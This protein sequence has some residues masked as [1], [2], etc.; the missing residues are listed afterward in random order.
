MKKFLL[1]AIAVSLI[2]MN[3]LSIA[4]PALT[5]L[6]PG[7]H[8]NGI[9][10]ESKE[11]NYVS[12]G[13]S[14][15]NGFVLPGYE[16][17]GYLEVAQDAYPA[18]FSAWLAGYEGKIA[19]GQTKYEGPKGT[20]NLTQLATSGTRAEDL[21]YVLEIVK[22]DGQKPDDY[23]YETLINSGRWHG[24]YPE[25]HKKA[26]TEADIISMAVGNANLGVQMYSML[27]QVFG[28]KEDHEDISYA[29]VENALKLVGV[30]KEIELI[31]MDIYYKALEYLGE[32]I[33]SETAYAA[34]GVLVY[35]ITSFLINYEGVLDCI[36]EL[37]PDAEI[38]II[39]VF[40]VFAKSKADVVYEGKKYTISFE[41]IMRM[42]LEPVNA[43][44]MS[45]TST[46]KKAPEY[47]DITFYYSETYE[48]QTLTGIFVSDYEKEDAEWFL[49]RFVP[50]ITEMFFPLFGEKLGLVD[51]TYKE[52]YNYYFAKDKF[53]AGIGKLDDA[54]KEK[55]IYSI[56]I[57]K[58]LER[59]IC[60]ALPLVPRFDLD[61]M[62]IKLGANTDIKAIVSEYAENFFDSVTAGMSGDELMALIKSD[63]TIV[64]I[65]SLYGRVSLANGIAGHP[66]ADDHAKIFEDLC[67]SYLQGKSPE[68]ALKEKLKTIFAEGI[69]TNYYKDEAS[70]YLA[71]GSMGSVDASAHYSSLLAA[72]LELE[73]EFLDKGN[74]RISDLF[75]VFVKDFINDEYGNELLSSYDIEVLRKSY[76]EAIRSADLITLDL[77]VEDFRGFITDQ[78]MGYMVETYIDKFTFIKQMSDLFNL[79]LPDMTTKKTYEM[80]FS[81][82][83]KLISEEDVEKLIERVRNAVVKNGIPEEYTL[84]IPLSSIIG[85]KIPYLASD[86]MV[87]NLYPVEI[88][89]FLAECYV[90]AALNYAYYYTMLIEEIR[91]VNPE[92]EI[93]VVGKM[94]AFEGVEIS[95]NGDM[96]DLSI[97]GDTAVLL[98]DGYVLSYAFATENV[99]Y[100]YVKE[101]E[102]EL[103]AENKAPAMSDLIT[104]DMNAGGLSFA[105]AAF[106]A[107]A[108]GNNYIYGQIR[109]GIVLCCHHEYDNDCDDACNKCE[110]KRAVD[111]HVYENDC[112][113][114]CNVCEAQRTVGAHVYDNDCDAACNIC[115]AQREPVPTHTYDN[116]CDAICNVC[117]ESRTPAEHAYDNNCDVE[118]NECSA[119]RP[120][121]PHSY[122]DECDEECN[123]CGINRVVLHTYTNDCDADCDKCG[124]VRTPM[125]HVYDLW[126]VVKAA[127]PDEDG[128]SE[129]ACVI[130]GNKESKTISKQT[131]VTTEKAPV[132]SEEGIP[133]VVIVLIV[134][135]AAVAA[136]TA[137]ALVLKKKLAK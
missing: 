19:N 105:P 77:G 31:A 11:I 24:N 137:V 83:E 45:L 108:E 124:K 59:S 70:R 117:A 66:C 110:E 125:E 34:A 43:Y 50:D 132:K 60:E 69:I 41:K 109:D 86:N 30:N 47:K 16:R 89:E 71:I 20:V 58:A 119:V 111:E 102:S 35:C 135:V 75:D 72:D 122:D 6:V 8:S 23:T 15:S 61:A 127:T 98:M 82:F 81:R 48:M 93:I 84:E 94:N 97:L 39:G 120:P 87:F 88:T 42:I 107:S 67:A 4:T 36:A 55:K 63:E 21:H 118:C 5:V 114:Y 103:I 32:Y 33:P 96:V 2:L 106:C 54:A 126:V 9:K 123:V 22:E 116:D 12:L 78:L 38:I 121:L 79:S 101:A 10:N 46:K 13:D 17:G 113:A 85:F 99:S 1:K 49:S 26:I 27:G 3:L 57:Y 91:A 74:L 95:F 7:K 90:Y 134:A 128:V 28:Q 100:V 14:M 29:T 18:R 37:N 64:S 129:R 76:T 25:V 65:L 68:Y 131:A 56:E 62:G 44:L 40:N 73:Y 130:C 104:F 133:T 53:L 115:L 92:A 112:D 80:D 52:V 136:G 51:I